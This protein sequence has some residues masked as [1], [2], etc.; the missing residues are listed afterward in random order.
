MDLQEHDKENK[1]GDVVQSTGGRPMEI[2]M[3]IYGQL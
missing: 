1:H 3:R 2:I